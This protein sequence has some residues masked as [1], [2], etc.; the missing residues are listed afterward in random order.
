M[1]SAPQIYQSINGI[2]YVRLSEIPEE[3]KEPFNKFLGTTTRPVIEGLA[4]QDAI[5]AIDWELYLINCQPSQKI[6]F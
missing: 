1:E 6:F 2:D 4:I 3:H 5:F